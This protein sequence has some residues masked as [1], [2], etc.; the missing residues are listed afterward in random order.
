MTSTPLA[1]HPSINRQSSRTPL[2]GPAKI[3]SPPALESEPLEYPTGPG[4]PPTSSSQPSLPPNPLERVKSY[5]SD[6]S[7][8]EST[9]NG[10]AGSTAQQDASGLSPLDQTLEE[11]GMGKYQVQLLILCGL[12]WQ[13]DNM[14]L[15]GVAVILPRVQKDFDISDNWI[16]LLS[17]SI[18]AGMMVGAWGWGSYSDAHGRLPAFNL[19]LL[20]TAVFGLASAFSPNFPSLCCALFCLGT[21]VGGS[22]PTDGTLYVTLPSIE[23]S[24]TRVD[25]LIS[26]VSS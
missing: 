12:G 19:T 7:S 23:I 22:M 9:R 10:A 2:L 17:T 15:Q 18:F 4:S 16:G 26:P 8:D 3:P 5:G 1:V 20:F 13:A 24:S 14:Y 21:G 11:I 6:G 25:D